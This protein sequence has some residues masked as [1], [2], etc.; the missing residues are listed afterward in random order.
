MAELSAEK[1]D[2]NNKINGDDKTAFKV[3]RVVKNVESAVPTKTLAPPQGSTEKETVQRAS[4]KAHVDPS[5]SEGGRKDSSRGSSATPAT[6]SKE[7]KHQSR[8]H[9]KHSLLIPN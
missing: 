5:S 1:V 4:S 3:V 2:E 7:S 9:G 6:P 8:I